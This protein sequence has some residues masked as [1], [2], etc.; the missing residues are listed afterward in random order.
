MKKIFSLLLTA[1]VLMSMTSC[2]GNN[3]NNI[4]TFTTSMF[5]RTVTDGS[6]DTPELYMNNYNFSINY[7][8]STISLNG[9]ATIGNDNTIQFT[10]KDMAL[11]NDQSKNAVT[12]S[13]PKATASATDITNLR[14]YISLQNGTVYITY[15]VGANKTVYATAGL[16]F[17]YNKTEFIPDGDESKSYTLDNCKYDFN[18]NKSNM[19]ATVTIVNFIPKANESDQNR[20]AVFEGLKLQVTSNGYKITSPEVKSTTTGRGDVSDVTLKDVEFNIIDQGIRFRGS[21]KTDT[22][23]ANVAGNMFDES[24]AS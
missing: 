8:N 4:A 14:G 23:D 5:N 18:L 21:Y 24:K 10:I 17:S 13:C 3:D 7:D 9:T 11:T 16:P 2:L 12:F 19:T 6:T 15:S 22:Y 1:L 20:I